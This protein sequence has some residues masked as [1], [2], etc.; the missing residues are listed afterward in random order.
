[1]SQKIKK[2]SRWLTTWIKETASCS[3]TLSSGDNRDQI[4]KLSLPLIILVSFSEI[5]TNC[6]F[7]CPLLA[8]RNYLGMISLTSPNNGKTLLSSK[9]IL[10]RSEEETPFNA[11][12]FL[13][14][15]K[16]I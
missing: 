13:M 1:M 16:R 14:R 7:R 6:S 10:K 9:T 12:Y 5:F 3:N 4:S 8:L 15:T 2:L 11:A